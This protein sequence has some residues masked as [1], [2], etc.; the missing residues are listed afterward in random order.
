M[1]TREIADKLFAYAD[2]LGSR[3]SEIDAQWRVLRRDR[4][5]ELR[6][7]YESEETAVRD[8]A[9]HLWEAKTSV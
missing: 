3:K 4:D 2:Y 6:N 8:M 7:A 1:N 5:A 9:N